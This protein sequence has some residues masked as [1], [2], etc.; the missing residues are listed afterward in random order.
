MKPALYLFVFL[1]I[2]GLSPAASAGPADDIAQVAQQAG[3]AASRGDL[4]GFVSQFADNAVVTE[5][6]IPFRV[7]GKAAIKEQ[8]AL[9]FQT[10]PTRQPMPRQVSTR[11]YANET[12][13]VRNG[14]A[15]DHFTDKAGNAS[16]YY[17]RVSQTWV[18]IDGAWKI[19]DHHVSRMPIP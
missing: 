8:F 16:D 17:V 14:Y 13:A 19:V 11:V 6:W 18:K 1:S 9:L 7:E 3:A 5:F 10:Y 2:L 12:V 15:I 4:D